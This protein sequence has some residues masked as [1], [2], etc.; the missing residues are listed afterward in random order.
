MTVPPRFRSPITKRFYRWKFQQAASAAVGAAL[1][2]APAL[3]GI[4]GSRINTLARRISNCA[5]SATLKLQTL[6]E[7]PTKIVY[8][9]R[10]SCRTGLC[11]QCARYRARETI[12]RAKLKLDR[13]LAS[14]PT[15]RFAFLT[16]T[17]KNMPIADVAKM[18]ELHERALDRFWRKRAIARAFTGHITGIEIAIRIRNGQWEAG[19]HSHSIVSLHAS[20]FD[21][22]ADTYLT[23]AVIV[24]HW[25]DSLGA[26]YKPVCDIRAIPAGDAVRTT[27]TE[28][29][30]Y[31]VAPQRLFE[32]GQTGFTVDPIVAAYLGA[33]LYKRRMCRMG[34]LF[35]KRAKKPT[36]G[37]TL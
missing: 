21:K 30:K 23:Q 34:G 33:A 28:C 11:A 12:Q 15:T 29:L 3:D 22:T 20:Y 32:K 2:R 9:N 26:D 27:L 24:S 35:S 4:N 25:R 16:L 17:S 5:A 13:I 7:Q 36:N 18:L 6:P 10:R 1:H 37:D 8:R 14:A 19:V 31:A